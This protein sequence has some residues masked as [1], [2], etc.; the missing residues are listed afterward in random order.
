MTN[1]TII[2][3]IFYNRMPAATSLQKN[4]TDK[5][6]L[7]NVDKTVEEPFEASTL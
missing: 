6:T 2:D 5:I 1:K 7:N 3:D 4:P